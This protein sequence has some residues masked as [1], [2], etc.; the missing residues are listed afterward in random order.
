[1]LTTPTSRLIGVVTAPGDRRSADLAAIG[2]ACAEASDELI[3]YELNPRG[4]AT[5]RTAD[6]IVAGARHAAPDR[7]AQIELDIRQALALGLRRGRPGDLIVF[8]CA[9]TL[10]DLVAGVALHDPG[11]AARLAGELG[12]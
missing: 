5:G 4:R 7:P 2:G 3:V 6:A 8:T 10:D 11:E 12:R 9:G 1:M